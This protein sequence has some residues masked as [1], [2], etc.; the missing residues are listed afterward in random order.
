MAILHSCCL[1]RTVRKGSYASVIYTLFYFGIS[2][3]TLSIFVHD[4]RKFL[5]GEVDK[6][7]GESFLEKESISTVTVIFNILLLVFATLGVFSS[8][9]VIVGLRLDKRAFL[10][11]WIVVMI[12]DLL[13]ECAHFVYLIVIQTLRFEP[14]T[15]MLFTIDFFIMCLNIYCLLCVISQY[16]EYKAG[17]G[18]AE[19]E[20]Y[21]SSVNIQYSPPTATCLPPGKSILSPIMCP[22]TNCTLIPEETQINGPILGM[23]ITPEIVPLSLVSAALPSPQVK[24]IV[25]TFAR[26]N[27]LL[28]KK[29]VKFNPGEKAKICCSGFIHP[30]NML[31]REHVKTN[32]HMVPTESLPPPEY[33]EEII[34]WKEQKFA[35]HYN[36]AD[37]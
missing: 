12:A 19:N 36:P 13:V 16:Q 23:P 34:T 28:M 32:G 10:L 31:P 9:L 33:S 21:T 24:P 25:P 22:H 18:S 14:V 6:P 37:K 8:L 7:S 2:C 11:P 20:S 35:K 27:S 29:H 3:I 17:R 4:E 26:Q 5:K 1:W 15:A 30:Q